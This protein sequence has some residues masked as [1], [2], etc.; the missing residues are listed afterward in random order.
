MRHSLH[1][2]LRIP[3]YSTAMLFKFLIELSDIDRGIYTTLDFRV[4]QHPSE[5]APYLL[6]RII[7][8]SLSYQEGIEFAAGG[9]SDPEAPALIVRNQHGTAEL[10]I[11]VG[12]PSARKLHKATKTAKSVRV[13]TYKSPQV[14]L[15]DI[16]N[17]DVH[18]REEIEIFG[19]DLKFLNL[20]EKKL[21]KNNRW[22]FLH[23]DGHLDINTGAESFTTEVLR[24]RGV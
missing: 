18:R 12:N 19:V 9:L 1:C 11:E 5:I 20:L 7:A 4:A 16:K 6:T 24:C 23:Q 22:N 13:Y 14:L 8:Y 21:T 2:N 17:N 3:H 10:W 15:D